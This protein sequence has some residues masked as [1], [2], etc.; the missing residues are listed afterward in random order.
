MAPQG[1]LVFEVSGNLAAFIVS[2]NHLEDED[3]H[4]L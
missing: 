1:G 3:V 2:S 4:V